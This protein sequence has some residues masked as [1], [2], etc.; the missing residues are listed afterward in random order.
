M[1]KEHFTG[2]APADILKVVL[3]CTN[4]R[5]ELSFPV[6]RKPRMLDKCPICFEEWD[7][8]RERHRARE[9]NLD[10]LVSALSY[11]SNRPTLDELANG[12]LWAVR[13]VIEDESNGPE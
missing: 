4:C 11:F 8:D 1:G 2:F 10:Q 13:L 5:G 3:Q 6:G 12:P 9:A 7:R